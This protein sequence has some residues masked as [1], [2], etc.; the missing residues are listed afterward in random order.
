MF[1]DYSLDSATPLLLKALANFLEDLKNR[2]I[3]Y[4]F[5]NSYPLGPLS[6]INCSGKFNS[7]DFFT[8]PH[9]HIMETLKICQKI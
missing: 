7:W 1:S 4:F 8:F 6:R 3:S 2:K 9:S 5:K